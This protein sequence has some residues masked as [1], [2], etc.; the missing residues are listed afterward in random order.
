MRT[1]PIVIPG[2][3][4]VEAEQRK[5]AILRKT[6]L[7][8]PCIEGSTFANL[9]TVL[10]SIVLH[11][12]DGQSL[13]SCLTTTDAYAAICCYGFLPEGSIPLPDV[14]LL[15][16]L[17]T[18]ILQPIAICAKQ[19]KSLREAIPTKP[20]VE[21]MTIASD[22]TM[23]STIIVDMVNRKKFCTSFAAYH[24]SSSI[25]SKN[26][27]TNLI[28]PLLLIS[29]T[30]IAYGTAG[31]SRTSKALAT[32]AFLNFLHRTLTTI[33]VLASTNLFL[34][35]GGF[36]EESFTVSDNHLLCVRKI[37]IMSTRLAGNTKP[38]LDSTFSVPVLCSSVKPSLTSGAILFSRCLTFR[39]GFAKVK[40]KLSEVLGHYTTHSKNPPILIRFCVP[41]IP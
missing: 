27:I 40:D 22:S 4:A 25:G 5:P 31:G 2:S 36:S 11:M 1:D 12:V 3:I 17:R 9:S 39:L 33:V 18:Y 7:A 15:K 23:L 35:L 41:N 14:G 37:L 16:R 21:T 20:S 8:Q 24:T 34:L 6:L 32:H 29:I 13:G 28:I 38:T 19:L 26:F 10:C 30:T